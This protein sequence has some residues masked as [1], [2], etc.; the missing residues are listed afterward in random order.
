MCRPTLLIA[1]L[2]QWKIKAWILV[3]GKYKPQIKGFP[4][5]QQADSFT[6]PAGKS[7]SFKTFDTNADGGLVKIYQA[8]YQDCKHCPLKPT[9]VPKRRSAAAAVPPNYSNRL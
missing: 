8:D 6:C 9:C 7:L 2:E 3:F 5:N 4:Y 1:E